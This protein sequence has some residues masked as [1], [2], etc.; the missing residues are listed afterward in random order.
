MAQDAGD[1][2]GCRAEVAIPE[3]GRHQGDALLPDTADF[4]RP[5]VDDNSGHRLE[6]N[7]SVPFRID[8]QPANAL[9][10]AAILF[11]G[12][13][14][15][16]DLAVVPRVAGR[17]LA[18]NLIDY[19][20]GDLVD[21]Q[22]QGRGALAV[23]VDPDFRMPALHGRLDIR[24]PRRRL[25]AA[26]H[27]GTDR[28][29]PPQVESGHFD[30]DR[31]LE[32][33]QSRPRKLDAGIWKARHHISQLCHRR[34]FVGAAAAASHDDQQLA[35]VL[36]TFLGIGV[37]TISGA[38]N[39]KSGGN[40][41]ESRCRSLN[42]CDHCVRALEGCARRQ[43]EFDTKLALRKLW[44]QFHTQTHAQ[45]QAGHEQAESGAENGAAVSQRPTKS[46][47]IGVVEPPVSPLEGTKKWPEQ[48]KK[49]ATNPA[50]GTKYRPDYKD[51]SAGE[52]ERSDMPPATIFAR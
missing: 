4:A 49:E 37:E 3:V 43:A 12:P 44:D 19:A 33:E 39:R 50:A 11:A 34:I 24:E 35:P 7:R 5:R 17:H 52:D 47:R 14:E 22:T 51:G 8:D 1:L 6:R 23:E 30:L 28:F 38:G 13:D 16:V 20:V 2:L 10:R 46:S 18:A 41:V 48:E 36:A 31:R 27:L 26:G 25:K 21:G 9:Q 45:N 29:Q 42:G 15:H 40:V 32:S